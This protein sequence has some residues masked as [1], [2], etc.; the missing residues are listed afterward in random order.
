MFNLKKFWGSKKSYS[1]DFIP[2][3]N[4]FWK[5]GVFSKTN[6]RET[7]SGWVYSCV[8]TISNAI[9][10][11]EFVLRRSIRSNQDINHKYLDFITP[12]LLFAISSYLELNWS[13]YVWMNKVWE[14]V[15]SLHILKPDSM[16]PFYNEGTSEIL[17]W[18][19]SNGWL[20]LK[21][22]PE[23]IIDFYNF[24]PYS[25]YPR[26]LSWVSTIDAL[27]RQIEWDNEALDYNISFFKNW[28][29]LGTTFTSDNMVTKEEAERINESF[30]QK[31]SWSSKA[32]KLAVLWN[33]LKPV[34]TNF[35]QKDLDFIQQ[36]K[37]TR[38]EILWIFGVPKTL[39]WLNEDSNYASARVSEY[40][41]AKRVIKPKLKR[42]ATKLN[43][44]LF[45]WVWFID[46][47]NVLPTDLDETRK[48]FEVWWITLNEFRKTRKLPEVSGWNSFKTNSSES[49]SRDDKE[50]WK[51]KKKDYF[52]LLEKSIKKWIKW[53]SKNDKDRKEK[54][55]RM[56]KWEEKYKKKLRKIFEI[57]EKDILKQMTTKKS[58]KIKPPKFDSSKYLALYFTFLW[59]EEKELLLDEWAK[60]FMWIWLSLSLDL[61]DSELKD[62][63]K[64]N[65]FKFWKNIDLTTKNK[66]LDVITESNE[67]WEWVSYAV[68]RLKDVFTELKTSRL[69]K[70]ARTET[71]R[72][73]NMANRKAWEQSW[74][75]KEKI[76]YTALDERVCKSCWPM[77]GK[78]IPLKAKFYKLWDKNEAGETISYENIY[79]PPLHPNCRCTLI[80]VIKE[81]DEN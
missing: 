42:I 60:S 49:S 41:F 80:P 54:V 35:N 61:K 10:E 73:S 1:E 11:S 16:T 51:D 19:Y 5:G 74:V 37:F 8:N 71:M 29:K 23:E 59:S 66:I 4:I 57:Q 62:F 31:H 69:E 58:W 50:Q 26:V 25:A 65:I 46:F 70:I 68:K 2:F 22:Y 32:F 67:S 72:A 45:S 9:S 78:K 53:E 48:D 30:S 6:Y 63:M 81:K 75:V 21:F 14:R 38:D 33:G 7:Y 55:E 77:H 64:N 17:Y 28:A 43:E 13:A 79:S 44:K 39:L 56:K 40:I 15:I 76:W 52:N 27:R 18:Q 47:I 34:Q 20:T 24:N 3:W 36:R 12:E